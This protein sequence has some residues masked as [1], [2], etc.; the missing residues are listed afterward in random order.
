[1]SP[2][3]IGSRG[4]SLGCSAPPSLDS[5]RVG[6]SSASPPRPNGREPSSAK[7]TRVTSACPASRF[8]TASVAPVADPRHPCSGPGEIREH[9]ARP[10]RRGGG[11]RARD[12]PRVR[13][14]SASPGVSSAALTLCATV[15]AGPAPT[16]AETCSRGSRAWKRSEARFVSASRAERTPRAPRGRRHRTTSSPPARRS[17]RAA[18]RGTPT[19]PPPRTATRRPTPQSI[20]LCWPGGVSKRVSV[21]SACACSRRSGR[22]KRFT[23]S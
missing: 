5:R 4:H 23:V 3:E 17:R 15:A 1:M 14:A 2:S 6:V 20:W 19:T 18:Q 11:H 7:R 16:R 8:S 21:P 22:T 12:L 9:A 10:R 13:R